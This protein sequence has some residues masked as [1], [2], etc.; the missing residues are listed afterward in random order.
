M[1]Y[2]GRLLESWLLLTM[3]TRLYQV[4]GHIFHSVL[5]IYT[6]PNMSYGNVE[7]PLEPPI[8]DNI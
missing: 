7:G 6:F 5:T 3:V 8:S 1:A 2:V 4:N